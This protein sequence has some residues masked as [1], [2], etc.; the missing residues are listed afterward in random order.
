MIPLADIR[1][2]YAGRPLFITAS[3]PIRFDEF[4]VEV[5]KSVTERQ[6]GT[7]VGH[8]LCWQPQ[9]WVALLAS[10]IAGQHIYVGRLEHPAEEG[11]LAADLEASLQLAYDTLPQE[12]RPLLFLPTGGTTGTPRVVVHSMSRFLA[13]YGLPFEVRPAVRQIVLYAADHLAG[14]DT[15]FRAIFHGNALVV[16]ERM[17][18]AAIGVAIDQWQVE[19][20]PVTPSYLQF[21]LLSGLA[22]SASLGSLR[23]IPH[24]AEPMPSALRD[25]VARLIPQARLQQRFGLSE[26]GA[27]PVRQDD[28]DPQWLHLTD[29]RFG[30]R[31]GENGELWIRSPSSFLGYL[32][33]LQSAPPDW[34]CSGDLAELRSDGALR[35]LGRRQS[36]INVGG[37]KVIPEEV[38]ALL[39]QDPEV[40]AA[41]A[42]AVPHPITGQSVA[43]EI[44]FRSAPDPL[45]LRRRLRA[46]I[47][48]QQ[49][50]LA[51]VPT[52]INPVESL[53][54]TRAFKRGR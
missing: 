1:D 46:A 6:P 31:I 15:F 54:V 40:S 16:P 18:V 37:L 27:V 52:R 36:L 51:W 21:L 42:F 25:L 35:I 12:T 17:D 8:P 47:M 5:E 30:W 7:L 9:D 44:I 32:N 23:I 34:H 50:P 49:L 38:E 53:P 39:Q 43:A 29:P 3:G 14:I 41:R 45:A 19:V 2:R 48:R 24:G 26:L 28:A 13:A 11:Q 4:I 22:E 10:V 33:D 20:M